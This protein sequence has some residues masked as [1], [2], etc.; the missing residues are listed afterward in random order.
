MAAT[1]QDN[2]LEEVDTWCGQFDTFIEMTAH[3]GAGCNGGGGESLSKS[4]IQQHQP[5][6]FIG[7]LNLETF[8]QILRNVEHCMHQGAAATG[9]TELDRSND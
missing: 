1:A 7:D 4:N 6:L 8:N 2:M 9:T 3:L 5:P